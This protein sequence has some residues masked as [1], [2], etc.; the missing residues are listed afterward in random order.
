MLT[1]KNLKT[2]AEFI[3]TKTEPGTEARTLML[4]LALFVGEENP[5]FDKDRFF[6]AV[7]RHDLFRG[8]EV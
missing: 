1:R 5:L 3:S 2:L 7:E 8:V 4:E 6:A